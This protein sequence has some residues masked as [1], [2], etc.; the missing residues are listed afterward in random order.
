MH[1]SHTMTLSP[2]FVIVA[3]IV[4]TGY[5]QI[6]AVKDTSLDCRNRNLSTVPSFANIPDTITHLDFSF[7]NIK[8]VNKF[9][10]SLSSSIVEISFAHNIITTIQK[11]VFEIFTNVEHLDLSYNKLSKDSF[12]DEDL[13]S[14]IGRAKR[15]TLQGNDLGSL[16]DL[17]FSTYHFLKMEY[18]DLSY[19]SLK[20]LG[21]MSINNL[22]NLK[23]LNLSYNFL[24][25]FNEDFLPGEMGLEQLDISY[26]KITTVKK[27]PVLIE[28]KVL[29]IDYNGIDFIEDGAFSTLLGL[30]VLSL[31]GN[32]MKTL[33]PNMLPLKSIFSLKE[34]RLDKN[35]WRC[36]CNMKWLFNDMDDDFNFKNFTLICSFPSRLRGKNI[37]TTSSNALTCRAEYSRLT[38]ILILFFSAS[39]MVTGLIY[40]V[41]IKRKYFKCNKCC[42]KK[43]GDYV[44]VF[45]NDNTNADEGT[46][47]KITTADD[48]SL[49]KNEERTGNGQVHYFD[50]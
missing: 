4:T 42:E 39:F 24:S 5:A 17:T 10:I 11:G 13:D 16:E 29:R 6:C 3:I 40:A 33:R 43:G 49:V 38:Y 25:D 36:D 14:E 47:V 7:N 32:N 30:E 21:D 9:N 1:I 27:V 19:C 2:V 23:F 46:N 18:L 12:K 26:N 50:V 44:A 48:E 35:P 28:L 37:F 34:I 20:F 31:V 8:T 45:T 22:V 15:L 41:Y